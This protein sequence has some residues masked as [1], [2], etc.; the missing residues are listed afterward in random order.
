MSTTRLTGDCRQLINLVC[1]RAVFAAATIY[2]CVWH[3]I[4][5]WLKQL[6]SKLRDK[7]LFQT[8][9]RRMH[10]GI[11]YK[12]VDSSLPRDQVLLIVR[13]ELEAFLQECTAAGEL[14]VRDYVVRTWAAKLGVL[15]TKQF[16]ISITL[17]RLA[18]HTPTFSVIPW[19]LPDFSLHSLWHVQAVPN[20]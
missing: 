12:K 5:A 8:Y 19:C 9:F 4:N 7:A 18:C 14:N 10:K 6:R 2:L 13:A 16:V 1:C 20:I 17:T 3:V 11:M 15:S